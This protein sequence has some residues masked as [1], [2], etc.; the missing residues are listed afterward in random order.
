MLAKGNTCLEIC[1]IILKIAAHVIKLCRYFWRE[2]GWREA[3][4]KANLVLSPLPRILS[5]ML[6]G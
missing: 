4:F 1:L 3:A 2:R 5:S 6:P